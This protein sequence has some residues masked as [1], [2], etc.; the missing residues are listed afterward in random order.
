[1]PSP[2]PLLECAFYIPI[3]GDRGLS[4]GRLHTVRQWRWLEE[5]LFDSFESRGTRP[6]C[7]FQGSY[8][9]ADTG[10]EV[11]DE[12]RM[13]VIALRR[14]KVSVL[15]RILEQA[16]RVFHQKCIYL[17]VAGRVEFVSNPDGAD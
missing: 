12:S 2:A 10:L 11:H 3:R 15:R 4:P 6:L 8:R 1:M 14:R 13:Y 17:S 7:N 9:D 16:C 5:Q